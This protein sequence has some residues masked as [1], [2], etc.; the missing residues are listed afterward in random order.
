MNLLKKYLIYSLF[1]I[2]SLVTKV[3]AVSVP[4][5]FP[6]FGEQIVAMGQQLGAGITTIYTVPGGNTLYLDYYT[7]NAWAGATSGVCSI[8][9]GSTNFDTIVL[10]N[11]TASQNILHNS[12]RVPIVVQ[13]SKAITVQSTIST[14]NCSLTIH[15]ILSQ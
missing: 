12:L 6:L 8:F 3:E 5:S 4:T 10:N 11:S 9:I 2:L 7:L 13:G 15:G 14:L 1:F